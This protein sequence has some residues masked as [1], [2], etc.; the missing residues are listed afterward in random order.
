MMSVPDRP[1]DI[2]ATLHRPWVPLN[3][4]PLLLQQRSGEAQGN[5]EPCV[6]WMA[7]TASRRRPTELVV[8]VVGVTGAMPFPKKEKPTVCHASSIA[9]YV[10]VRSKHTQTHKRL[11]LNSSTVIAAPGM[12]KSHE[13]TVN[14]Y[15]QWSWNVSVAGRDRPG[16][17]T[18]TVYGLKVRAGFCHRFFFKSLG[19]SHSVL[20]LVCFCSCRASPT[21][22][23][24][25]SA[26]TAGELE[27]GWAI[28]WNVGAPQ[29]RFHF[30]SVKK[31]VRIFERFST[32]KECEWNSSI[33][34]SFGA[35]RRL[36]CTRCQGVMSSRPQKSH[37][38]YTLPAEHAFVITKRSHRMMSWMS[39]RYVNVL[40]PQKVKCRYVLI[41]VDLCFIYP[42]VCDWVVHIAW[43]FIYYSSWYEIP[44]MLIHESI[45]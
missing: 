3:G 17:F 11:E 40:H 23:L 31:Q 41:L 13:R 25:M 43:S 10:R 24:R 44:I 27:L 37:F 36:V 39:V 16:R 42:I 7:S 32:S 33:F 35:V 34:H 30:G 20:V 5:P 26:S 21:C 15:R 28:E 19:H 8:V 4:G 38:T 29:T 1:W 2:F 22:V 18:L 14:G 45:K 6:W 9:L 12:E